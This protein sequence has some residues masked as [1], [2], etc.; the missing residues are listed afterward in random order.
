M[1]KNIY[2]FEIF[3]NKKDQLRKIHKRQK[4]KEWARRIFLV[5]IILFVVLILYMLNNSRCEYYIYKEETETENNDNVQYEPF[6]N[7]YIKYGQNGIEYQRNFGVAEWN[8][9]VSFQNPFLVKAEPYIL[10]ADKGGNTLML[11]DVNGQVKDFTVRY[12]V[13]QAGVSEKGTIEV[14]LQGEGSNLIQMYDVEGNLV[15]DMRSSVDETGYPLTAAISPDGSKL[16]VSYLA[17]DGMSPKTTVAFY[18]FSRQLQTEGMSL[19]GGFDYEDFLIARLHFIDNNT[20]VA[21]GESA[22]YYYDVSGEPEMKKEITFE[23]SIE[24]IFLG[25]KYIGYVLDN[26]ENPDE[27]RYRICLYNKSG[28]K[29]L[30]T[31]IDMN[32][33]SIEMQ[34][35]Q[36]IAVQNNECTIINTRGKILFQDE[37]DGNAIEAILPMGGW[38]TYQVVFQD[39]IAKMQLRFW[40]S[41]AENEQEESQE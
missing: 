18:D 10:L 1:A 13:I 12:P 15:A 2:N 34:G 25:E 28:G 27:G 9:P 30:D 11:F 23:Q 14:I 35:K 38:R 19:A 29:K 41:D 36:I 32:Y 6:A 33:D 22:T 8:I 21:V 7:G 37:L 16:V 17:I 39:K 26:S 20:L 5:I 40:G 4:Q 24:S 3:T 31:D